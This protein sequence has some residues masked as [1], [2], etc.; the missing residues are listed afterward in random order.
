MAGKAV[1]DLMIRAQNLIKEKKQVLPF[2]EKINQLK[3]L[4]FLN[5]SFL[6]L[7]SILKGFLNSKTEWENIH[8]SKNGYLLIYEIVENYEVNKKSILN[9][10]DSSAPE[11]RPIFDKT[12]KLLRAFKKEFNYDN[13]IK[14]IRHK[15]AG[16]IDREYLIYYEAISKISSDECILAI[17]EC[18]D[19]LK[20]LMRIVHKLSS[21]TTKKEVQNDNHQKTG[22]WEIILEEMK[23]DPQLKK[24]KE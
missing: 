14:F 6:D 23:S 18:I 2:V 10:I 20:L 17:E 15:S 19:F 5:T 4:C 21:N 8:F 16:H 24:Y 22:Y 13:K 11:L 1:L 9:E 3:F 7:L 12:A